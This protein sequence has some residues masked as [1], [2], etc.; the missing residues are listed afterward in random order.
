MSKSVLVI[1]TPDCC[2]RCRLLYWGYPIKCSYTHNVI[3]TN[4]LCSHKEK[5]CPLRPLPTKKVPIFDANNF[6]KEKE[7]KILWEIEGYNRC[8]DEIQEE[9]E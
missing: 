4:N 8:I 7:E 6:D 1:D 3:H 2:G 5:D 9:K